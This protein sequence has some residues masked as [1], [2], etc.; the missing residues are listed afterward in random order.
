MGGEIIGVGTG[1]TTTDDNDVLT[2]TIIG[3]GTSFTN[4]NLIIGTSDDPTSNEYGDQL[5]YF[6]EETQQNVLVGTISAVVSDTE[7]TL[8]EPPT[9]LDEDGNVI[10]LTFDGFF[11]FVVRNA[12]AEGD[13]VKGRFME[14]RLSK[15]SNQPIEIFSVGSTVFNSELS[16]D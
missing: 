11:L 5:F 2:S 8:V 3:S 16:D 10:D 1:S 12:F 6:D 4:S 15:L 14:T 9:T 7:L 13:R